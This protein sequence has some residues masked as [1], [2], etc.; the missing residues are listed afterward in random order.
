MSLELTTDTFEAEVINSAIPVLVDF[1]AE[2]CGPCRIMGPILDELSGEVDQL[3]IKI[4]KLN[5]DEGG[6]VAQKFGV[7]SIPAFKVFKGG[8][9]VKEFTGSRTKD[10]VLGF[11][12]EYLG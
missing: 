7:M 10:E 6:E 1:W 4:A 3:K 5:V 12:E 11:L 9:V 2:W 8:E